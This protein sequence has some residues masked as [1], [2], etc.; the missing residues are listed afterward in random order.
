MEYLKRRGNHII[1]RKDIFD[2]E[3]LLSEDTVNSK[4]TYPVN[5]EKCNYPFI[6]P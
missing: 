3:D 2:E 5:S 4:F 1:N 6:Y